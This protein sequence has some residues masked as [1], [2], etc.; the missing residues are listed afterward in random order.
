[1]ALSE[2]KLPKP[3]TTGG[4]PLMEAISKRISTREF[5][6]KE[7]DNQLL[8]N[9]LWATYGYNREKKRCAPSSHNRQD[10]DIYLTMRRG[11]FLWN[12]LENSLVPIN[13]KDLRAETS[14]Q[15]FP[16]YAPVNIVFVSETSRIKGKDER[17]I[18]EAIFANTGYISEN[19]YL[20]CASFGL[21]TVARAMVDREKLAKSLDLS[22]FQIIT[23]AQTV[24]WP[25]I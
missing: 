8:S 19:L 12:P 17:G 6:D 2:I 21:V 23:L 10:I 20:F 14:L 5:S 9:L 4:L 1:M 11:T 7:I 13:D 25:A 24:G 3:E 18:V 16:A 22:P 15:D